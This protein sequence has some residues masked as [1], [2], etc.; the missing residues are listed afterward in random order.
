M[1]KGLRMFA[2]VMA[3]ALMLPLVACKKRSGSAKYE[4]S[5]TLVKED[6]PYFN[7]EKYDLEMETDPEKELD[8]AYVDSIPESGLRSAG[9]QDLR[10]GYQS[11]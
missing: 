4:E 7:A 10:S 6:D 5:P 9:Q 8:F 3:V 1:G 11:K 2:A